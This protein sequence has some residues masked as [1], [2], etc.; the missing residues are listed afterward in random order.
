MKKF[1]VSYYMR[2]QS[3]QFKNFNT[4]EEAQ[5]F[6]AGLNTNPECESFRLSIPK[7]FPVS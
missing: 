1:T 3:L 4:K 2:G 7:T 5:A 6:M